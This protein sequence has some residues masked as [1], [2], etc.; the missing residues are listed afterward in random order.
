MLLSIITVCYNA[1]TEL[2]KTVDSVL[3]QSFKDYEYIIIDGLSSDNS[4]LNLLSETD[5]ER[6]RLFSEKDFGIYNA[7]NRGITRAQG[8]F[9]FFLNAGDVFSNEYVLENMERYLSKSDEKTIWYGYVEQSKGGAFSERNDY[10]LFDGEDD[11]TKLLSGIMPCHQCIF[12]PQKCLKSYYFNESYALRADFDWLCKSVW[13]GWNI[14]YVPYEIAKFNSC[15]VSSSLAMEDIFQK[16]TKEII[17]YYQNVDTQGIKV[18]IDEHEYEIVAKKQ[19]SI[20][21]ILYKWIMCYISKLY[22]SD[23]L[24]K[25]GY[26]KVAIYG[27]GT[28]GELLFLEIKNS[29]VVDVA[30]VID[31][32]PKKKRVDF[33]ILSTEDRWPKMDAVIITPVYGNDQIRKLIERK[34]NAK[35]LSVS[36]ILDKMWNRKGE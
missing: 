26:A 23:Y 19:H 32:N 33:E 9:V 4:V 36:E 7:M 21:Q 14:S 2:L 29:V 27:W 24:N 1:G 35:V 12:A 11:R 6:I 5:D 30:C 8:D 20:I 13:A 17:N 18:E 28:I 31:K 22:I 25:K 34:T 15:G 3:K 10:S 16:E